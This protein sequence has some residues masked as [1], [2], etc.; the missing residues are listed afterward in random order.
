MGLDDEPAI[1]EPDN[2]DCLGPS[3]TSVNGIAIRP[4]RNTASQHRHWRSQATDTF[5]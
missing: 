5:V 1:H 3:D 4:G 2:K